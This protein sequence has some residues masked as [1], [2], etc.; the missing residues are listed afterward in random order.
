M[1]P[2]VTDRVAWSVCLSVYHHREPCKNG[3][4]DRDIVW[5]VDLGGPRKP[6]I[7]WGSYPPVTGQFWE[8]N[9]R[10]VVK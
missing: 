4:T 2:V 5:S 3:Q 6:Y 7:T 10:S 1:Q 9:G 8:G